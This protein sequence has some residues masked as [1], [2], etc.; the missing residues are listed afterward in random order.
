[1]EGKCESWY[2]SWECLFVGV[3]LRLIHQN[4]HYSRAIISVHYS[5]TYTYI[6]D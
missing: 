1:M 5:V 3:L 2:S 4:S 6:T